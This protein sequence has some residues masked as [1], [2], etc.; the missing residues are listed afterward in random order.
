[1]T[2]HPARADSPRGA[3]RAAE[4]E[5]HDLCETCAAVQGDFQREV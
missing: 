3:G 5:R 1:M 4:T 2:V